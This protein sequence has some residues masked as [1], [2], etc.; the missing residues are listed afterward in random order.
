M[1]CQRQRT[2]RYRTRHDSHRGALGPCGQPSR[3]RIP[4]WTKGPRWI[5]VIASTQP[6][7]G[8]SIATI[9]GLRVLRLPEPSGERPIQSNA[10]FS[11][12]VALGRAEL[13]AAETAACRRGSATRAAAGPMRYRNQGADAN[14]KRSSLIPLALLSADVRRWLRSQS[15]FG[16][17][18]AAQDQASQVR[19][20]VERFDP[21]SE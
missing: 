13:F 20:A 3:A 15:A 14:S 1:T 12:A 5:G 2:A 9:W 8:L 6:L 10:K 11:P 4:G 7:C 21:A 19:I 16:S 17:Q 18:F